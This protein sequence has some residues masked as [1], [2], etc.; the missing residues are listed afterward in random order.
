MGELII[1]LI[2]FMAVPLINVAIIYTLIRL[3]K[4]LLHR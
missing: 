3:L 2:Q 1:I 4:K